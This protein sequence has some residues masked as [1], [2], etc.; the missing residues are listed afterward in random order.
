[1][2]GRSLFTITS[3]IA[4]LVGI[5]IGGATLQ[6]LGPGARAARRRGH[7]GAARRRARGR[8]ADPGAAP[9][10]SASRWHLAE[11]LRGY[12][13]ILRVPLLRGLLLLWWTPLALFVGAES[14]AVAYAGAAAA[15]TA[16]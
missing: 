13:A 6:A 2:L 5:A 4:Q 16:C 8:A 7:G 12:G 11:T 3:M 14:L 15:P 10:C 9:P 1:M